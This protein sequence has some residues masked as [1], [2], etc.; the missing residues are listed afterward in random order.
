[1]SEEFIGEPV[2]PVAGTF[3]T[4]AMTRGEPALPGRFTWRGRQ[5]S[6]AEVLEAWKETG[7]C[8]SGGGEQY[9]RKHWYKI[10]TGE[11]LVMTMYF[12]RQP[13]SKSRSKARW[14]LYAVE[15]SGDA[16]SS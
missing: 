1:M 13:R 7:P 5:Y 12:E 11:G 8:K 6:T 14:W 4:A 16:E 15:R 2:A 9:L 10:R 3:E